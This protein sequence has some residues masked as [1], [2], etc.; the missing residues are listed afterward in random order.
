MFKYS[1]EKKDAMQQFAEDLHEVG[2][3]G[4]QKYFF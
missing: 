1:S 3:L 4:Q 2:V